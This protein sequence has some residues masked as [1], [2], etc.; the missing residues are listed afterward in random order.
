MFESVK[1]LIWDFLK[2]REV[3][4]AMIYNRE[5]EI[6]WHKGRGIKGRTI[7][8]GEGFSKSLILKTI[9]GDCTSIDQ[10]DV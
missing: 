8:E 4:L 10:E 6:L 3:S 7:D 5:G 2:E 1:T 9:Q